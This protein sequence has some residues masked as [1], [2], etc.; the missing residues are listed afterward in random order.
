MTSV[1]IAQLGFVL[2]LAA[3]KVAPATAAAAAERE[4]KP[5]I[6]DLEPAPADGKVPVVVQ[7]FDGGAYVQLGATSSVTYNGVALGWN[8]LGYAERVPI[9]AAGGSITI[10]HLRG[11]VTTQLTV[12][13]PAR[14]VVMSPAS[15]ASLPRTSVELHY[16]A[17]TS[18]GIRPSASDGATGVNGTE[19]PDTGTAMLEVST[20]H[21]GAGTLGL[22]RRITSMQSDTGFASATATYTIFSAPTAVVWQ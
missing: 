15:G 1:R 5:A 4:I 7:F 9:V 20:L 16:I 2:A 6:I 10:A 14:P 22:S 12:A 13:V 18:A 8:G 17:A 11:G 19:Q 21:A 3:C